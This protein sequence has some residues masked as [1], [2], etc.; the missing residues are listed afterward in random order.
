MKKCAYIIIQ[1][2]APKPSTSSAVTPSTSKTSRS[3]KA[4][5]RRKTVEKATAES[6]EKPEWRDRDECLKEIPDSVHNSC[7]E[8]ELCYRWFTCP[9]KIVISGAGKKGKV[10]KRVEKENEKKKAK[11]AAVGGSLT[12]MIS[13]HSTSQI[14]RKSKRWILDWSE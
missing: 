12:S 2:K 14:L 8:K 11:V 4:L 13:P 9:G 7:A 5:R 3:S 10:D 1:R 6:S